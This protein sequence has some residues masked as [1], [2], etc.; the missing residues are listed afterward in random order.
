MSGMALDTPMLHVSASPTWN[1]LQLGA[2]AGLRNHD[3]DG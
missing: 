3:S 2:S 1:D